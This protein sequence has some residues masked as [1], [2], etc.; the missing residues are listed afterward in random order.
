MFT[1][2]LKH[3]AHHESDLCTICVFVCSSI[4][5]CVFSLGVQGVSGSPV[6]VLLC[7]PFPSLLPTQRISAFVLLVFFAGAPHSL[8]ILFHSLR[9]SVADE[10]EEIFVPEPGIGTRPR[11]RRQSPGA[12]ARAQ[13]AGC[14]GVAVEGGFLRRAVGPVHRRLH[15]LASQDV[16]SDSQ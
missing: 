12:D 7:S 9:V 1:A 2:K 11:G 6:G 16:K 4:G 13:Q 8:A 3:V 10:L 15:P 5:Q 14:R